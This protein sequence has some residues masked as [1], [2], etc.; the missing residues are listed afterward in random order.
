MGNLDEI[1]KELGQLF[2]KRIGP[3][4]DTALNAI[5]GNAR[6]MGTSEYYPLRVDDLLS[7]IARLRTAE[8]QAK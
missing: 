4:G 8:R 5:E 1:N 2:N 3:I 7:I 6:G